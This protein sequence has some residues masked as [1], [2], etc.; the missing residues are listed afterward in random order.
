MPIPTASVPLPLAVH[1]TRGGK[2]ESTHRIHAAVMQGCGDIVA[3]YGDVHR[4]I[5]PRSALKPLQTVALV[6]SGAATRMTVSDAE[7][8][9]A[10]ASHSGEDM[11]T[12]AVGAWLARIGC[13][14]A[15]LGCGAHAPYADGCK[16]AAVLAN[17]CSG[18]H[19]G[20][21]TLAKFMDAPVD[22]YLDTAHPVQQ[23]I[24]STIADLCGVPLTAC[25]CGID[26]CSAPNPSMPLSALARGFAHFMRADRAGLRRGS[27]CRQIYQAMVEHPLLVGGSKN[28]LDTALMQAAQ[29][30]ILSKT[31]AEGCYIAVIP[32]K[33]MVIALKAEDGAARAA[34]AALYA[35]LDAHQ[36][37]TP[38]VLAAIEPLCLP[39]LRNWGGADV[40]A[41]VIDRN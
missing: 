6:E 38:D 20:M 26:G 12:N 1:L 7:I 21:L 25:D 22:G 39:R 3:A 35:L 18:K 14:E 16:P 19:A 10:C 2:I 11:H 36:L 5:F 37:A 29:G 30:Q 40:G 15:D 24:L 32:A 34:Q 9:L 27:A 41:T 13:S 33:D 28:R 17:N 23:M 4:V 31:G 8:A